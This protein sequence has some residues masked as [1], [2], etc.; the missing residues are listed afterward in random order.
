MPLYLENLSKL[1][2]VSQSLMDSLSACN[3]CPRRCGVNRLAGEKGYCSTTAS[4]MV[5]SYGPHFGE[6]PPLVGFGGSGTIFLTYCN[7]KCVFCQNYDISHLGYGEVVSY[8]DLADMMLYLQRRGCHNINFVTPTHFVPQILIGVCKAA[9]RG[10][11]LPIVYNCGGYES[12]D[13]IKALEGLIDI[14]MPDIKFFDKKAC[15]KYMNAPDYPEVVKAVVKEMHRQVGE[16]VIENHIAVKGLL[17]RHLVMP[18]YVEDSKKILE[19]IRN[20]ISKDTYVNIMNQYRPLYRAAEF[21]E[22]ARRP[23]YSEYREVV[24]YAEKI[25]LWRGFGGRELL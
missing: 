15:E 11:H 6:E 7:L 25:G 23:S 21:R 2:E 12:L 19:F 13:V 20:E 1:K 17:I 9:L 8:D 4:L 24:E 10:L 5:S 3:L 16:L 22:I 18:S 14:Y